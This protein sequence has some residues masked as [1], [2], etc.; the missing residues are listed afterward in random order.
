MKQNGGG[1][2]KSGS[3]EKRAKENKKA[4]RSSVFGLSRPT[5]ALDRI[6]SRWKYGGREKS[7]E[8]NTYGEMHA[9]NKRLVFPSVFVRYHVELE[10][11]A[12][13]VLVLVRI[14][15][16]WI[17]ILKEQQ[18]K[19]EDKKAKW[20]SRRMSFQHEE[21]KGWDLIIHDSHCSCC[22]NEQKKQRVE[23]RRKAI[24]RDRQEAET[25]HSRFRSIHVWRRNFEN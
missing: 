3:E 13:I 22:G 25:S 12:W 8:K 10:L 11:G 5:R 16:G 15:V 17:P 6:E 9:I 18:Q 23:K 21:Q 20:K 24:L 4:D 14:F 2:P 7:T 1:G 19:E